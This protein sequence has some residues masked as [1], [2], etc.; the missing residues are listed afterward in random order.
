MHFDIKFE[1]F[2]LSLKIDT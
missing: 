1:Q 2:I